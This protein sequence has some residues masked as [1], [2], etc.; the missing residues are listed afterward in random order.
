MA[1]G[2]SLFAGAEDGGFVDR[3]VEERVTMGRWSWSSVFADIN[4]DGW[5]DLVVANGNLTQTLPDD[6]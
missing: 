4:N 6:L 5:E 2:N 3:S 1:R